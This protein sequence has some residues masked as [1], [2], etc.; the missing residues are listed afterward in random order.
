MV[1]NLY[2]VQNICV[3]SLGKNLQCEKPAMLVAMATNAVGTG[4]LKYSCTASD[5]LAGK[6][7]CMFKKCDLMAGSSGGTF[8][9]YGCNSNSV[10]QSISLLVSNNHINSNDKT[11]IHYIEVN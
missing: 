10:I 2:Y 3:F 5:V 6:D 8:C 1:F 7:G 11:Y 4:L 9:K